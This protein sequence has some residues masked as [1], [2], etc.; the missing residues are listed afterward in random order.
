MQRWCA[1]HGFVERVKQPTRGPNLLDLVLTDLKDNVSCAVLPELANHRVAMCS[2][3]FPPLSLED[4]PRQCWKYSE[5]NWRGLRSHLRSTDWTALSFLS[6][7]TA[8]ERFTDILV[9]SMRMYI[10]SRTIQN[11]SNHP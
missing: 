10:P 9:Q 2:L 8:A 11:R 5:A 3:S 7:D 1:L 4:R 6:V